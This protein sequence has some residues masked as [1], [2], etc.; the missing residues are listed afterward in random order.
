MS[1]TLAGCSKAE[2]RMEETPANAN[3][4]PAKPV[5]G[6][7]APRN[8]EFNPGWPLSNEKTPATYNNFYEF[9][10]VN[11]LAHKLTNKFITPPWLIQIGCR[12]RRPLHSNVRV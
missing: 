10:T 7:P 4:A 11:A 5:A 2:S 12:A 9:S 1:A 8:P 6:D 3:A